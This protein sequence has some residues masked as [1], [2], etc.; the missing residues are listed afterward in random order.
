MRS[1]NTKSGPRRLLFGA[2]VGL[3]MVVGAFASAPSATA[4]IVETCSPIYGLSQTSDGRYQ[5]FSALCSGLAVDR[6]GK[7]KVRDSQTGVVRSTRLNTGYTQVLGFFDASTLAVVWSVAE[8]G[9]NRLHLWFQRPDRTVGGIRHSVDLPDALRSLKGTEGDGCALL[10]AFASG[11]DATV[12]G[13]WFVANLDGVRSVEVDSSQPSTAFW[14]GGRRVFVIAERQATGVIA[15]V[16]SVNCKGVV[17]PPILNVLP[18][19]PFDVIKSAKSRDLIV[20]GHN[21]QRYDAPPE[22][23]VLASGLTVIHL[24]GVLAQSMAVSADGALFAVSRNDTATIY[25]SS[26]LAPIAEVADINDSNHLNFAV[27][28]SA[29]VFTDY[30]S[31]VHFRPFRLSP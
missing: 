3:L 14:L 16:A 12:R 27:D 24:H 9:R 2:A 28:R 8:G 29:I 18:A 11:R 6:P 22:R 13:K 4:Q 5:A 20:L 19:G 7:T 26:D 30:K 15:P 23:E 1:P 25:R 17:G 31:R 21:D 10:R